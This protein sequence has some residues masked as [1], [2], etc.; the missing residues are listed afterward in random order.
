V[1]LLI[2]VTLEAVTVT[3]KLTVIVASG[4][5]P[6]NSV[7]FLSGPKYVSQSMVEGSAFLLP[8]RMFSVGSAAATFVENVGTYDTTSVKHTNMLRAF[9]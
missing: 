7:S 3:W 9:L 1:A 8:E 2:N 4:A 6:A 5:T